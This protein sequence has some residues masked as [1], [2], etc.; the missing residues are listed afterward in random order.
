MSTTPTESAR[1]PASNTGGT[2]N[3]KEHTQLPIDAK[4]AAAMQRLLKITK[5]A[6]L[7]QCSP[8]KAWQLVALHHIKRRRFGAR[9]VRFARADIERLIERSGR[10]R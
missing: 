10:E 7:L 1:T 9:T 5:V 8:R 6:E 3:A 2:T 4:A